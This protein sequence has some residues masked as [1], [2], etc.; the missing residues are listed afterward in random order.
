MLNR[1]VNEAQFRLLIK[2][3]GPILVQSGQATVN[4]ANM[5]PMVT[6]RSGN[7]EVFLPGSS[8]KGVFR[9]HLEKIICS[10]EPQVVCD[11]F[12][13]LSGSHRRT[14]NL[15]TRQR[16]FLPSCGDEFKR[17]KDRFKKSQ[18]ERRQADFPELDESNDPT[19]TNVIYRDS[20]PTCRLFGSTSFIGRVS[21]SDAYLVSADQGLVERRDGVGIDRLTGGASHSAKFDADVV[22]PGVEFL[23]TIYIR[24]FEIWQLGMLF[25][26]VRDLEAELVRIGSGRSRGLGMVKAS[27]DMQERDGQQ[28]GVTT[29][30][31][32]GGSEPPDQLW[33]LGRWLYEKRDDSY[34]TWPNDFLEESIPAPMP[35]EV[36]MRSSRVFAGETLRSLQNGAIKQFLTRIRNWNA[37]PVFPEMARADVQ[38]V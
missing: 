18:G 13:S 10:V 7:A 6:Y 20:C 31:I 34:G 12:W 5:T 17:R 9:S 26:V 33:G 1:L 23:T 16:D 35:D 32:S 4:G 8:L 21:I 29:S 25:Q 38:E 37:R 30:T 2:T 36:G 22:R 3:T 15:E 11:P 28:G 24:N 19:R 14:E 27:I